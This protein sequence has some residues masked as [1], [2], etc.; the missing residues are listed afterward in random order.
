MNVSV[1]KN[2]TIAR[3][4][5]R[6]AGGKGW[7]CSR[8]K[9]FVPPQFNSYHEIFLGGAAFF[10][11]LKTSG[12]SYLSD[13]NSE[14]INTYKQL[15]TSAESVAAVLNGFSNSEENYYKLRAEEGEDE[16]YNAA[17]FIFLNKTCYNGI[18]RVNRAGKFNVPYGHNKNA[19]IFDLDNLL[20]VEKIL[21]NTTLMNQDFEQ[22]IEKIERGDFAFIDPPY[23]VAHNNNGFIEYNQK[24]F[25]WEDQERLRDAIQK[26]EKKGAKYILMNAVHKGIKDLYKGIGNHYE[27]NRYSTITSKL[28]Y[29]RSITEYLITNV[30]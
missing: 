26:I 7:A 11:S 19:P 24:L 27:L 25:K 4:F 6:W 15:M 9:S 22:S 30:V 20:A 3:P 21:Q 12:H 10:F 8:L 5:L 13:L 29:R 14:L 1:S 2:V 28:Q 18:F 17:K 16:I 23:T